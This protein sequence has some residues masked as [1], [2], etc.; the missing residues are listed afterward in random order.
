MEQLSVSE[1]N[2]VTGGSLA[3]YRFLFHATYEIG[4]ALYYSGTNAYEAGQG[5]A[6]LDAVRGGNLGA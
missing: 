2:D 4:K 6:F 3:V 1:I 5:D